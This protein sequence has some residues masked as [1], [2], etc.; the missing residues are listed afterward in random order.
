MIFD[1]V[2]FPVLKGSDNMSIE[3]ANMTVGEFLAKASDFGFTVTDRPQFEER[4]YETKTS[5]VLDSIGNDMFNEEVGYEPIY[6]AY[7]NY[8][9]QDATV[10]IVSVKATSMTIGIFDRPSE[11]WIQITVNYE[12][13]TTWSNR[14]RHSYIEYNNCDK[15]KDWKIAE[16]IDAIEKEIWNDIRCEC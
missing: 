2:L 13:E 11:D 7:G 9:G 4:Y 5:P 15:V 6:D 8:T 12:F 16:L 3:T 14:R 10:H 1:G